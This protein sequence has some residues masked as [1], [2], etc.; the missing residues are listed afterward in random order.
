MRM[1]RWALRA[2]ALWSVK[3]HG[4]RG[5]LMGGGEE[6]EEEEKTKRKA[7]KLS[8]RVQSSYVLNIIFIY[9]L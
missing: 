4:G 9:Y 3:L 8:N 6:E 7:A 5:W 2:G 1:E